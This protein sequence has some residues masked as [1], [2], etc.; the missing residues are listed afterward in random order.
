MN[1]KFG[2][3]VTNR[4]M[5]EPRSGNNFRLVENEDAPDIRGLSEVAVPAQ[6]LCF[7]A[8][9][10]PDLDRACAL[11]PISGVSIETLC[12]DGKRVMGLEII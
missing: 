5:P 12:V 7:S 10:N 11:F 2:G 4:A 8:S 1:E 9:N 6:I 3:M